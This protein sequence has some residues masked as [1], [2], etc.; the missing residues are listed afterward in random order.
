MAGVSRMAT[1]GHHEAGDGDGDGGGSGVGLSDGGVFMGEVAGYG[2]WE[3]DV[4]SQK[5]R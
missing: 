1:I 4:L 3:S 5:K 2:S